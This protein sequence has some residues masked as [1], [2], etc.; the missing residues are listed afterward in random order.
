M[1][2]THSTQAAATVYPC[3]HCGEEA[4]QQCGQCKNTR[5]CSLECQQADW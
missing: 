5:Y 3:G 1:A 4:T 2:D